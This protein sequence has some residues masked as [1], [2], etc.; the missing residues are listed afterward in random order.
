MHTE[1]AT[2]ACGCFWSKEY[3]FSRQRGVVATRVGYT[4]GHSQ[5]PTY[6][7]VCRK[8]T[9]HCEAVEVCFDPAITDFET[10]VRFFF[11]LHDASQDRRGNGGQYR[12]AIFYHS[13]IQKA[14]A[15]KLLAE[16]RN[17][18]KEIFTELAPATEFREAEARHQGWCERTGVLP[19]AMP[20]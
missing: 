18:G 4:G 15:E 14:L 3:H 9:G 11:T 19:P 6:E 17:K 13:E 8:G 1:C 10:L 12:S 7:Q 2:F 5:H 20:K 16:Q